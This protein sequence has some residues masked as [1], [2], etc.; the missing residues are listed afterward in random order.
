LREEIVL[1]EIRDAI[2]DLEG[3]GREKACNK[4]VEF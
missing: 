4:V 3:D 2:V 1:A